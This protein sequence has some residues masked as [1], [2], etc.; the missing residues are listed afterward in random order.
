VTAPASAAEL[1][2]DP[3]CTF[4]P[5]IKREE[6]VPPWQAQVQLG[7][8][9]WRHWAARNPVEL[10]GERSNADLVPLGSIA[11][12]SGIFHN[13]S[14]IVVAQTRDPRMVTHSPAS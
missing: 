6:Q 7:D 1:V 5:V 3:K 2:T 9:T 8:E 4:A 10:L 11:L 13:V 12:E 14:Y